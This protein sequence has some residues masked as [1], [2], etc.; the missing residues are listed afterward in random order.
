MQAQAADEGQ[1]RNP[2]TRKDQSMLTDPIK[3]TGTIASILPE[4]GSFFE[5]TFRLQD[6]NGSG[7]VRLSDLGTIVSGAS[8][9]LRISQQQSQENKSVGMITDRTAVRFDL[10][11]VDPTDPSVIARGSVT[12]TVA[13]PRGHSALDASAVSICV[14][15]LAQLLLTNVDDPTANTAMSY[16]SAR[17]TRILA[18]EP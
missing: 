3:L 17:I 7:S 13:I 8:V 16:S 18:G 5:G 12:L 2:Y 15:M 10:E 11:H 14:A 1:Q 4:N 9:K 6:L